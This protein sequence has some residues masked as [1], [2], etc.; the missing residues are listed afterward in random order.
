[1][2]L[3]ILRISAFRNLWLGQAVSQVGDSL[4]FVIFMF[5]VKK[6]S[7]SVAMVGYVDAMAA[8]PFLL[9]GPIAGVIADRKDR[10]ALMI[11][12]DVA[13]GAVLLLFA[14]TILL[15]GEPPVWTLMLTPF[16]LSTMRAFFLPAKNAA[17]PAL[18]PIERLTEANALSATTQNMM[19]L[20]GLGIS[21]SALGVLYTIAP[22]AFFMLAVTLNA[23]SFL[24]SAMFVRRLPPLVPPARAADTHPW[25]DFVEGLRY[26]R[27]RVEITALLSLS[28]AMS[29]MV[30]PFF[31]VYVAS[32]AAWYGGK[33]QTLAWFEF[34][35]FVGMILGSMAIG[36]WAVHRPGLGYVAGTLACGLTVAAM[37]VSRT[38]PAFCALNLLAGLGLPYAQIP[39]AVYLQSTVPDAF[40][41]RVNSVLSTLSMGIMPIGMALGGVL[42]EVAGLAPAFLIMGGG[43]GA[44]ALIG[45]A[46]RP[47][48][49]TV[50]P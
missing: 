7:G 17:I 24:V 43:M 18:V 8:L 39:I 47:F 12:S 5:M 11:A 50:I 27:S 1:M 37:A 23:V 10:R 40:M 35:F 25:R 38:F 34:S 14:G 29:L 20:I 32:N 19:P 33:P 6:I 26:V 44:V 36:R 15:F 13:S 31:V 41:G 30:S 42:V 45:W 2:R 4:Y 49:D 21:A 28:V 48:R 9:M 16:L 3:D 46:V 22:Q